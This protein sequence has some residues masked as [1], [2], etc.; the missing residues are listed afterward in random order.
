MKAS[1]QLVTF[2]I[3]IKALS[4]V[5]QNLVMQLTESQFIATERKNPFSYVANTNPKC[6]PI[7][8]EVY[9]RVNLHE[10]FNCWLTCNVTCPC[11]TLLIFRAFIFS[12]DDQSL[13]IYF[14]DLMSSR[15]RIEGAIFSNSIFCFHFMMVV[16][17][18]HT[19]L[20]IYTG[21]TSLRDHFWNLLPWYTFD[22]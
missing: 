20:S 9:K 15:L 18:R 2:W 8:Y 19:S 3:E 16:I 5:K 4:I 10:I 22:L 7:R 1:G 6:T 11:R 17:L 12:V 21:K 14:G 13:W